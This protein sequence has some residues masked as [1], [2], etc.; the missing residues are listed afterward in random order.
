MPCYLVKD[1]GAKDGEPKD[2]LVEAANR[3]SA[4]NH[5]AR[6]RFAVEVAQP[7]D[8]QRVVLAGG[9]IEVA[10]GDVQEELEQQEPPKEPTSEDPPKQDDAGTHPKK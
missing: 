1:T 4:R 6:N 8:I 10:T 7:A 9:T 5:V 3:A 2:R